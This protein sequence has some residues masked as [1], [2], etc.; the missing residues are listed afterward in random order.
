LQRES[1]CKH[2][3]QQQSCQS[4]R[5]GKYMVPVKDSIFHP[6]LNGVVMPVKQLSK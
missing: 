3:H 2:N 6:Q 4:K 5:E 1:V